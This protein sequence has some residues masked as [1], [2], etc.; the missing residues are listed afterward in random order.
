MKRTLEDMRS[1]E[2]LYPIWREFSR[3]SH[4]RPVF[5][6]WRDSYERFKADVGDRPSKMHRLFA[7]DRTKELGP[8]NFE[9][10]ERL[11][12]KQ[13]GETTEEYNARHRL[14]RRE[15]NGSA[16]W[17]SDLRKKYGADYGIPQQRAMAEAQ[18]HLCAI[19]GRPEDRVRNGMVA[20]LAID[21]SHATKKVR[22]MLRG[23]C[24]TALG[25]FD[26]DPM[27]LAKAI[28]YLGKHADTP[29]QGQAMVDQAIA[30]LQ[31]HP[32]STLDRSAIL[33]QE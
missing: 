28:L 5:A 14:A 18:N 1:L 31:R 30:Y 29:E 9:W 24:N 27:V 7:R 26:D 22:Q 12:I 23:A 4:P 21:H 33:P 13:D 3:P 15:L 32:V 16:S 19:S 11:V 20:H 2:D 10:R 25:L 8:D 17:D 6:G